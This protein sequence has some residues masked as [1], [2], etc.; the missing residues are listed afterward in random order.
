MNNTFKAEKEILITIMLAYFFLS[1][2][3]NFAESLDDSSTILTKKYLL[4]SR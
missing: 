4:H 2:N 1:V 3:D